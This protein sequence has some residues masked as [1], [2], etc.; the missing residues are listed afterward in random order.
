[1]FALPTQLVILLTMRIWKRKER[2]SKWKTRRRRRRLEGG[3]GS[4]E[5]RGKKIKTHE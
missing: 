3:K 4:R 2:K 5:I 1:M